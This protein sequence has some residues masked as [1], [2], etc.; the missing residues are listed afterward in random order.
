ML[1]HPIPIASIPPV[2]DPVDIA[3]VIDGAPMGGYQRRVLLFTAFSVVIDGIDSQ[4]LGIAIPV[5]MTEW[6]VSRAAFAPVLAAGFVGM[7]VGGAIAGVVGDRL[8]RRIALIGS[9]LTFGFATVTASLVHG[10][11]ALAVFRFFVGIGLQGASPN[12]AALVSEY[13]P[14]RNRAFAITLTIVCVPAG[15]MLAGLMAI[16]VLPLLGWRALFA[17]GGVIPLIVGILLVRFLPESP[18]Y[19]VQRPARWPELSR[20]LRHI[21]P[22]IR[23]DARFIDSAEAP[24]RQAPVAT[25]FA[26][27]LSFDTCALWSAFF[28]CLLAVYSGFNWLPSMLT[29][30]GLGSIA[31]TG[32]TAYNLGGVVGAVVGAVAIRRF[33]SRVTMLTIAALASAIA[34]GMRSMT[35]SPLAPA[36][37]ILVM[38]A[39]VGSLINAVQ[40]TMYAL[41]AYIYPTIARSTGIGVAS[42]VGRVGAI[43]STYAGAWALESGG[44]SAFFTLVAAAMLAV[45]LSLAVVRRHI[46]GTQGLAAASLSV[47]D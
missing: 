43:L 47:S 38:L 30:A 39:V 42:S 22:R 1:P 15:A 37:P 20:I 17:I 10:L 21:D 23:A 31:N 5:M 19:L 45:M 40:V 3:H 4:L 25:L 11:I 9:V 14:L 33:G 27:G 34:L 2:A 36:V 18:R 26:R 46:P 41:G 44:S 7:M 12:A 32:I 24:G 29:Q 8:G 13:A 35:F 6:L 16:P 28:F